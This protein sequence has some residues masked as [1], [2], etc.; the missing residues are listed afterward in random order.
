[1]SEIEL[2]LLPYKTL[3][4]KL[5]EELIATAKKETESHEVKDSWGNV[6]SVKPIWI[7]GQGNERIST[8]PPGYVKGADG[9]YRQYTP[10][11]P[12]T[13]TAT[14]TPK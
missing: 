13:P 11:P 4:P 9:I 8:P 6:T 1:M 10:T 5:Y 7:D 2:A 12:A 3:Y 14:P